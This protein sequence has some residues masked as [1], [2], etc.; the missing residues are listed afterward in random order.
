MSPKLTSPFDLMG[1][2]GPAIARET[3]AR[4]EGHRSRFAAGGA[5]TLLLGGALLSA[6]LAPRL[7]EARGSINAPETFGRGPSAVYDIREPNI[8]TH[9]VGLLTLQVTNVGIIG[10]PFINE[11]SAGW[12]GGEYLYAS[13]LWFG[14]IG[15]DAEPH[16]STAL[17]SLEFRPSL[18]P[19]DTIY[20]S[21][22]GI[23]NGQRP[24]GFSNGDDDAD[25][26]IDEDF[27]NGKDD[28]GDGR[29]DEDYAAVGQQMFACEYRDDTPEATNQINDHVPLGLRVQQ[30]SFQWAT[31]GINEFV[32]FDYHVINVGDQRLKN[33]YIGFFA[34]V[35]AGPKQ[36]D[37]YWTDDLCGYV[38]V[39][40]TVINTTQTGACAR[41]KLKMDI[42][43]IFDAP[44][45]GSTIAGGDVPGFFGVMFLGHT[46][47]PTGTLAPKNVGLTTVKWTA[48]SGAYPQGDPR[49]DFERYDLLSKGD[50]PRR[51]ATKPDDY[52]FTVAAG[53]FAQMNPADELN[54]QVAFVI[55]EGLQGMINNAIGA[56]R[57]FNGQYVDGDQ[58]PT[59]GVDGKEKCLHIVN[60]GD[61][62]L[63]D[64][65]CDTLTTTVQ[66]KNSDCDPIRFVDDDC[67]SC[68]GVDGKETQLNWVGTTAPPP[69]HIN[70]DPKAFEA[71]KLNPA[72]MLYLEPPGRD[73]KVVLQWDNVSELRPD[74]ITGI[75]LFEGYRI[76]K[77]N[78]WQRPE[79]S[80]GP[81]PQ[82]WMLLAE[83]RAHPRD[84]LGIGS[85]HHLRRIE[86]RDRD[87]IVD[88][89]PFGPQYQIGRYEWTDTTGVT[90]GKANF[91]SITAFGVQ[92]RLNLAT[93]EIEEVV[94]SGQPAAV[95]KEV[96]VSSWN[97]AASGCA[98]VGVV[99]NPYRGGADWDLTPADCDPTGTKVAFRNL[100]I[101]WKSLTIY[102]L[103]GDLVLTAHPD[104]SRVLGGCEISPSNKINGTFYWDLISRNGQNVVSGIYLYAIDTGSEICRGRFVIIR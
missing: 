69:P 33:I 20:E 11:L 24:S 2:D 16:V 6:A 10:N 26:L 71:Q 9:N 82:E 4:P 83:F 3:S 54:F 70:T 60:P 35:D 34:D 62:I 50:I 101:G 22:E 74:P 65:P 59:T 29:I 37:R 39:D 102:T 1:H 95:Q 89:T 28:D 55:G 98:A 47:D 73:H 90:D 76:W 57:I 75:G 99:P 45:N 7:V 12:R 94:L 32:G 17:Y 48:A 104:D 25:G 46:T 66:Y 42:T 91:Y 80:V 88:T 49:T 103:A 81:T 58:N 86:R 41:E 92:S 63:W 21:Y 31:D 84:G 38:K 51:N 27:N 43:Y 13:G 93:G 52:R 18:L 5:A 19:V 96:V 87:A 61:I 85:P 72:S 77:V 78:S 23:R 30:R 40:T 15:E 97:Y 68:T 14:A 36:Q 8:F 44:D 79:G 56:Q 67:N 100:P 53:P 64:N